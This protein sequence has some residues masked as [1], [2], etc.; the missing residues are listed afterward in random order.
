MRLFYEPSYWLDANVFIQA[1][2]G[3]YAFDIAP[4]FWNWLVSMAD[5]G[6]FK[7]PT[8]VY[9]ELANGTDDLAR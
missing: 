9:G 4:S 5:Q 3:P 1:K 8:Q 7:S 2:N 6:I